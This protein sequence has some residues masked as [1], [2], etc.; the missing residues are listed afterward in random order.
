MKKNT[1]APIAKPARSKRRVLRLT[2]ETIRVLSPAD[3]ARAA[4]GSDTQC[5]TTSYTT[6]HTDNSGVTAGK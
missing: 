4:G 6:E 3:L 5:S 1:R 2:H